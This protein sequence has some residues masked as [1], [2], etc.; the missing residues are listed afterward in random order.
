M[1][2]SSDGAVVRRVLS[3]DRH[4]FG[5]LVDRHQ[6]GL[7]AYVRYMGFDEAEAHD[8]V[9][10]GFVRAFRHLRRCG[11]PDRFE[12]WLF[13]IVS[14]LCR[15]VGKRNSRRPTESL[16]AH[17]STLVSKEPGP[18]EQMQ[19]NVLKEQVRAALDT[20]PGDQREA[21][22]LMYLRGHSVQEIADLTDTSQSA[23]KMRLKRGRDALKQEL[24]PLFSGANES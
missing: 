20:V 3:G 5:I 6:R 23:V 21:L 8:V 17:R 4:A 15:T 1:S 22:V 7:L 9:Q 14:N 13:K 16:Q 10:D 19:A 18:E 11:E 2:D 24:A 12:G